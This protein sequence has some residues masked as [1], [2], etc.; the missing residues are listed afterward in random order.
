MR[1]PSARLTQ[2]VQM[3]ETLEK[4]LATLPEVKRVFVKIGT[5]EPALR[6]TA[7]HE[8]DVSRRVSRHRLETGWL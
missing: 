1:I 4:S 2:S 8:F 5:A 3:Q 6:E 7:K